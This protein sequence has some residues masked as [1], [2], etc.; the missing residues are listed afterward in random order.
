MRSKPTP[1]RPELDKL[2]REACAAFDALTPEQ[3]RAHRRAQRKSWVVGEMLIENP[4]MDREYVEKLFEEI[5][6][7][8]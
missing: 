5:D 4:E 2:L 1:M 6:G 7:Q 8:T 3:Q